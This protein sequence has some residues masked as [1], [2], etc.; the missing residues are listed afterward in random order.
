LTE[1]DFVGD[2]YMSLKMTNNSEA[3]YPTGSHW[4]L[5]I[6]VPASIGG[7]VPTICVA[8]YDLAAISVTL[9]VSLFV[10]EIFAD[11]PMSNRYPYK[12]KSPWN[13]VHEE[14]LSSKGLVV[15]ST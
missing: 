15:L 5:T 12:I 11:V 9:P 1:S 10:S 8:V 6:Y 13:I 2:E 3:L 4:A 7:R 14:R